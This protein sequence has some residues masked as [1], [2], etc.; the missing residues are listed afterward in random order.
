MATDTDESSTDDRDDT[1]DLDEDEA[2]LDAAERI[3]EAR[4]QNYDAIS[5]RIVAYAKVIE[6]LPEW[7]DRETVE[8]VL[9]A[10]QRHAH[11]DSG[12]PDHPETD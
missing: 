8:A 7:G 11:D 5:D 10:I 2:A 9:E 12:L 6:S 3:L 4:R 1:E